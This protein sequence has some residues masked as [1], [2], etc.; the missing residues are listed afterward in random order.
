MV[1]YTVLYVRYSPAKIVITEKF[2]IVI[3]SYIG[4]G[5]NTSKLEVELC[6]LCY[7]N[8]ASHKPS[9]QNLYFSFA[10][11][12]NILFNIIIF[13]LNLYHKEVTLIAPIHTAKQY[14]ALLFNIM[15][16]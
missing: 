10:I 4:R 8:F 7:Q 16:Y 13:Y 11:I 14:T 5:F 1:P 2:T 9:E 12:V 15:F 3:P 6:H